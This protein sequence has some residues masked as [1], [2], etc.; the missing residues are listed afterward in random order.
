MLDRPRVSQNDFDLTE[1]ENFEV[2]LDVSN[3][4]V[5]F[6]SVVDDGGGVLQEGEAAILGW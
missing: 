4:P 5:D 6:H 3:S 1:I 2:W